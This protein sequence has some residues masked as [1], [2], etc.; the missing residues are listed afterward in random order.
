MSRLLTARE[1]P[2]GSASRPRPSCAGPA[3]AN[4]RRS[5]CPAARSGST[6]TISRSGSK[7]GRRPDEEC[8]PP[9]LDAAPA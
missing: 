4:C 6:R 2:T 5:G 9:R 1:S 7:N 3:A 8:Q